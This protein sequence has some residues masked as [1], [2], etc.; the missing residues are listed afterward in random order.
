M[1]HPKDIDWLKE[2]KNK[3]HIYT[4]YKRPTSDLG[5]QQPERKGMEKEIPC[6]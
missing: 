4:T 3:T 2:Y 5:T 1:F 6:K